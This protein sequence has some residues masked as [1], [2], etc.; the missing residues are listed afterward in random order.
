LQCQIA[1]SELGEGLNVEQLLQKHGQ[2]WSGG[3]QGW[4]KRGLFVWEA[5]WD[6]WQEQSQCASRLGEWLAGVM[7]ERNEV[8]VPVLLLRLGQLPTRIDSLWLFAVQLGDEG[9]IALANSAHLDNLTSLDLGDNNI[10][11]EGAIALA[12]SSNMGNLT[13][14]YLEH[15]DIGSEGA[16]ALANSPNMENLTSLDLWNCNIGSDGAF[17]LANSAHLG[18]LTQFNLKDNHI[19]DDA[20]AQLKQRFGHNVQV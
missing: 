16:I 17:A 12:N 13:L 18:K 9:A 6:A 15:N 8:E 11:S 1:E 3:L 20:M 2:E 14:L 7:L 10:G 4:W 5:D 19:G